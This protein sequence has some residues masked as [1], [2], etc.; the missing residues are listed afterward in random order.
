MVLTFC[1]LVVGPAVTFLIVEMSFLTCVD[2]SIDV[3]SMALM[4]SLGVSEGS[5]VSVGFVD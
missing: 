3:L 2:T 5:S 1:V 4:N